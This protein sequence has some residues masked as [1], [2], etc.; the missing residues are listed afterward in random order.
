MLTFITL[1]FANSVSNK[2]PDNIKSWAFLLPCGPSPIY[3]WDNIRKMDIQDIM[4]IK[5]C[6]DNIN[7]SAAIF[8]QACTSIFIMAGNKYY[9]KT[10]RFW[11]VEKTVFY[12]IMLFWRKM[13]KKKNTIKYYNEIDWNS[14]G[15]PKSLQTVPFN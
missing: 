12:Y 14:F 6:Q 5:S 15:G 4:D 1:Y 13:K 8:A 10:I 7:I 2:A 11:F 9:G 3:H